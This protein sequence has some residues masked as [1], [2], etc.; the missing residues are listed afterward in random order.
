MKTTY[1][2]LS[3]L[4]SSISLSAQNGLDKL[5]KESNTESI[6]YITVEEL[7]KEDKNNIL[8]LDAR[9]KK[10]FK[11][12]HIEN[13]IFV[14]YDFFNLKKTTKKLNNKDQKIIVYCSLGIRS[15]DIAEKLKKAGYTNVYNLYG[16]IFEWKNK[17]NT[18]IDKKGIPTEKIHTFSKEWS[19]W[20]TNGEKIYEY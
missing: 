1:I 7:A 15:E 4:I 13:A 11:T 16:G 3:F 19:Q 17:S 9:E 12:S 6:P 8:L 14:G 10:E 18:V 20:L 2:F 5:L